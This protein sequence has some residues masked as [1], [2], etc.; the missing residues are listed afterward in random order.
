MQRIK[1]TARPAQHTN[2]ATGAK[3]ELR[4]WLVEQLG[5]R[6]RV[7]DCF[8]ASGSMWRRV[9]G[10]AGCD[11]LGLDLRQFDDARRTIVCDSLRYLR[12]ADARLDEFDLFDLDA[13]GSP[14][15]HLV[16]ICRRIRPS[17]G[18]RV[19]FAITDGTGFNAKMNGSASGLLAYVGIG[20]HAGTR[21]Q[22][23]ERDSILR[24]CVRK[25]LAEAGLVP[26]LGRWEERR[27]GSEMRY[28]A[29][30]AER[31]A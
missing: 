15:Q 28:A 12:H 24:A 14:M 26:V 29:V 3:V 22:T 5:G 27:G 30:T 4:R 21:V 6:P 1:K 2:S 11:Y 10:P 20:R 18:R 8:C 16:A 13:F 17:P 23:Q 7:L 25:A 19:G 31:P 9:Y